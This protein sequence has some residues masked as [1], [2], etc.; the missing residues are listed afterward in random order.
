MDLCYTYVFDSKQ[1]C[2]WFSLTFALH[3]YVKNPH[4]RTDS[5]TYCDSQFVRLNINTKCLK[6]ICWRNKRKIVLIK[7]KWNVPNRTK[8]K[9]LFNNC[10][11][12]DIHWRFSLFHSVNRCV[13]LWNNIYILPTAIVIFYAFLS[14]QSLLC[15]IVPLEYYVHN[16]G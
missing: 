13:Q 8:K 12:F 6:D 9:Y 3:F 11:S 7:S 10:K 1:I 2:I 5:Y 4:W 14:E 16:V 15:G